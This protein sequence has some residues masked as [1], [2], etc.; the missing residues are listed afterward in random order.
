MNELLRSVKSKKRNSC[1]LKWKKLTSRKH[2]RALVQCSCYYNCKY[3]LLHKFMEY[4]ASCVGP[5]AS[6]HTV[7]T[8]AA[9]V[10]IRIPVLLPVPRL[11]GVH[12]TAHHNILHSCILLTGPSSTSPSTVCFYRPGSNHQLIRTFG[13]DGDGCNISKWDPWDLI[14]VW[15]Y[16]LGGTREREHRATT[17][18]TGNM[19]LTCLCVVFFFSF[20]LA[21]LLF[22]VPSLLKTRGCAR[23]S[24]ALRKKNTQPFP[25]LRSPLLSH[26]FPLPIYHHWS[27]GTDS[28]F[29]C[30]HF[31]LPPPLFFFCTFLHPS[32]PPPISILIPGNQLAVNNLLNSIDRHHLVSW[33]ATWV[34]KLINGSE[35]EPP[36]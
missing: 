33:L 11:Q 24:G 26:C 12:M 9:H 21:V 2:R 3:A 15:R 34:V 17:L 36:R 10:T 23:L 16:V 6:W 27:K 8:K 1:H 25:F 13:W 29:M 5:V 19:T 35:W 22:F 32:P 18:D 20:V 7:H 4:A 28:N 30:F 31:H 14:L